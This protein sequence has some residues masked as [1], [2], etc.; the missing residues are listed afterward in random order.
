MRVAP[1]PGRRGDGRRIGIDGRFCGAPIGIGR[2][3]CA[4]I[5]ALDQVIP[6]DWTVYVLGDPARP[7]G[8]WPIL[9]ARVRV[10]R[11][12][13]VRRLVW[14]NIHAP[15]LVR[16]WRLGLYHAVDNVSLPLFWPKS[17][18][19]YVL[20]VHDLIPLLCPEAVNWRHRA[21][22][23]LAIRRVVRLADAI[24]VDAEAV[25]R[26]VVERLLV[27]EQRV[28]VIPIGVDPGRFRR[29]PAEASRR[30]RARYG[31]ADDAQII[32]FVGTVEPRKNLPTLLR[33]FRRLR[34]SGPGPGGLQLV[35]AGSRGWGAEAALR[36]A[37]S[38]GL[39][40]VV[41]TGPVSDD[42]LVALYSEASLFVLPSLHEGFGLPALEA[43][44]CGVP[45]VASDIPVLRE[46]LG[47]AAR[48]VAPTDVGGIATVMGRVLTDEAERMTLIER[49]RRRA[50]R[51]TWRETAQRTFAVYEALLRN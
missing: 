11:G 43:M 16:R 3:T 20:T 6:P 24:I 46:V 17:G 25:K 42:D 26:V 13:S 51:F 31:L 36:E 9:P 22:F 21:Y 48:F 29:P 35:I 2:Y 19:K 27:D 47:E 7:L 41:F 14:A 34:S 38:L 28:H 4:L 30:V 50:E 1:E 10:V 33:A 40:D 12:D 49:G 32:L 37:E 15:L 39:R 44:A 8:R 5:Q 45:V 18:I 23:R